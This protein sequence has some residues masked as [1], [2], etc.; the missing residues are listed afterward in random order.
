MSKALVIV[1]SPA[2]AKTISKYLGKDYDVKASVG[3]IKDLP[4]SQMGVDLDNDFEPHYEVIEGKGKV[5][6]DLRKASK[7]VDVI[8]L[9]PD[10]D[11][12]GE[13]IAWHIFDEIKKSKKPVFRVLFNEITQRGVTQAI[14]NPQALN[15][16]LYEAQQAR[17]ILDRIVGYQISPLLWDK[18][19]RG[20]SAGRVQS[21]AVRLVVEREAAIRA[22]EPEEY[23]NIEAELN[24]A[25]PPRFRARLSKVDGKK[26][27]V[28]NGES[29]TSV[30]EGLQGA[31]Y[32]VRDVQ[33]KE[34]KRNPTAPFTTSKLQQEASRH[35]GFAAKRTMQTAQKLY[36]GI[37]LGADGLV[38]L[39]TYMRTDSTRVSDDAL[40]M[41]R[42]YIQ[43]KYGPGEVPEKPNVYK[44]KKSAQDAHEAVRPTSMDFPPDRVKEYLQ[45]DQFKLYSLIWN[46]FVACQMN[47]AIYDATSVDITAG[48]RFEFRA[49]GSVLR[50]PGFEAV[51]RELKDDPQTDGKEAAEEAE[52]DDARLPALQVGDALKLHK[53]HTEQKFTKPPPRFTDA[54]LVKELEEK[55][56]GRPSTYAS[57]IQVILD[58]AY[59]EKDKSQRFR[60]TELGEIV[61]ELLV[62]N[63]PN[64]LN[65][66]FTAEMENRLDL[67]EEGSVDWKR[68]LHEFYDPFKQTLV[69][70]KQNMRDVKREE[71][72]TDVVCEKCNTH[73]MVI[74]WGKNGRFL[75]C[76]GYPECKST[77]EYRTSEGGEIEV[78]REELA[79]VDCP[80][81]GKPM[82]VKSG[83]FGRFFACTGYPEC[84]TTRP[85]DLGVTCPQC[86]VGRLVE[87]RSKKG[88]TFYSCSTWPA[89]DHALWDRP[90]A[91]GCQNCD[92]EFLV[93]RLKT[94]RGNRGKPLGIVCP[95]C[96]W[97]KQALG[98]PAAAAAAE[99]DAE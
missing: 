64:I 23:W 17:R 74:K 70:A 97:V 86:K 83:R 34:R 35:F 25:L 85:V 8:Y 75:G 62:Q 56:I 48:P 92:S 3:H 52:G 49:S 19:R 28:R 6:T 87:K 12:E 57:I 89:C 59:V 88:Q 27:D 66:E 29:A 99:D 5:V 77:R 53:L 43:K 42:E 9:A 36:E 63:F 67:V 61:T 24:A 60:P 39:I 16:K 72:P 41:V 15:E 65:V 38:G 7:E 14:A 22:F 82:A 81:C 91:E 68:L 26:A 96:D 11:R 76:S 46:R 55:G 84:K 31:A 44:T 54:T 21:V 73:T 10:P 33:K 47:P 4:K 1:E 95:K 93:E 50:Y 78:V 69:T 20:L 79:G 32:V 71:I 40:T 18:V 13:A 58:K 90:I 94:G 30:R 51:Y 45:P 98:T 37:D 2:K 80:T